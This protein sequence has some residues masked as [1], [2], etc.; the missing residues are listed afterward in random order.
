MIAVERAFIFYSVFFGSVALVLAA[1]KAV[2]WLRERRRSRDSVLRARYLHILMLALVSDTQSLPRFPLLRRAGSRML[3]AE[4]IAEVV[5]ATYG[6]DIS[7][8]RRIVVRYRM[9]EWLLARVRWSFGYRRARM[10]VLLGRLPCRERVI[11]QV[12]RYQ[13]SRNRYVRFFALEAQI[14]ADPAS[15]LKLMADYAHPFSAFEVAEILS[16]LRRGMLPV[17]YE[18]LVASP[19][20]N[21]RMV[22]LGI[23]RQFG[24]EQAERALLRLVAHDA[25]PEVGREA[26]YTLCS[27]RRPFARRDITPR[28]ALM[29]A[30]ERKSLLRNMAFEGYSPAEL[31]RLFERDDRPYYES[32]VR[33]YKRTLA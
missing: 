33:S 29:S 20:R 14:A 16:L 9:D 5:A 21:L 23:V 2:L 25:V 26:L 17:A 32:L 30:A 13:R 1:G 12:V 6:V 11:A 15:A 28:L 31:Q 27:M 8:V 19:V 7:I 18:P 3:L 10:L 24:I 4:V 22:G